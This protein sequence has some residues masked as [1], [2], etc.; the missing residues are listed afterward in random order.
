MKKSNNKS[1]EKGFTLIELAAVSIILIILGTLVYSQFKGDTDNAHK[2]VA[3]DFLVNKV[4][5][6]LLSCSGANQDFTL[7]TR[8]VLADTWG[9]NLR[10]ST[11]ETW[12]YEVNSFSATITYPFVN[13]S[14]PSPTISAVATYINGAS[15]GTVV[16]TANS[17]NVGYTIK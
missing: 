2:V 4:P 17:I 9:L 1:Y 10:T 14:E 5:K 11:G 12:S 8:T 16:T 6:A 7:C 3:Q 13:I 15:I